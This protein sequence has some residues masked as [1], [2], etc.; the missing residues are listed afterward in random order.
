MR[1]S[2]A[3]WLRIA[4]VVLAVPVAM[5]IF[6]NFAFF[7]FPIILI[8]AFPTLIGGGLWFTGKAVFLLART[9]LRRDGNDLC[10]GLQAAGFAVLCIGFLL[11]LKGVVMSIDMSIAGAPPLFE[12][13]A[14]GKRLAY[15]GATIAGV[16]AVVAYV[17]DLLARALSPDVAKKKS[18]PDDLAG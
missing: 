8:L 9:A 11:I 10:R 18:L 15:L 7:A 6:L 1:P 2:V 14:E 16:S 5:V 12:E 3:R 13:K 17:L 4:G